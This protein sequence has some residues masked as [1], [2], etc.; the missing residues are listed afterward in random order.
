MRRILRLGWLL[1]LLITAVM[2]S[3]SNQ[4]VWAQANRA[5][6][7]GTVKD[8]SG[9]VVSGVEVTATSKGTNEATKT[10]SNQDGIYVIPN[11]FPGQYSVEFK[12][13]G[14]EIVRRPTITLESTQ[15][16][17]I[18][19]ELKVG[20]IT[21]T[22]TVTADAPVL[23]QERASIGTNMKGD[24]VTDLPLSIYGGGR[25]VENFA[26]AITPGYS[27]LSSPY[28]ATVNGGQWFTKDYTIDGTSGTSSIQGDSIETGPSMEAVSELQAQTS[29]IDSASAITS[30]GV[31]SFTLKSGTNKL[32]GSAFGYGHNEFL[33]ANTW[34]NNFDG[35]PKTKARAWDYGGSLGGPILREKL[36]FFGT[37]ERYT[38]NDF[39]LGGPSGFVP[40]SA[41][42]SGD[43]SALLGNDLCTDAGSSTGD[44]GTSNGNGGTFS[45]SITVQNKGGQTVPLQRGMIFD[46]ATCNATGQNCKQFTGN[47]I[48]TPISS[49]AQKINAI[50]QKSYAPES[51]DLTAN[52]RIPQSNS[53]S[54]TPIQ[55][56]LKLDYNLSGRD[57]LS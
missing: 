40:T 37:F 14:F 34:Q 30:G 35:A 8:S 45:N 48:D 51:T 3:L 20:A 56:V 29:G 54:Q 46:P 53:P 47:I 36:F 16:A 21:D 52:N 23:D 49:V 28:G 42:L 11:L 5:S 33:D 57:K 31:M 19:A 41:M 1:P 15:V 50:F 6:I 32:H 22:I 44:C 9:A 25:F 4:N 12:R 39:T 55:A 26:V 38:Q 13:D 18:N 43:F 7:T 2:F 27:P 17:Q 24:V 10:T